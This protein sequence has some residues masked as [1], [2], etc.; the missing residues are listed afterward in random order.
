MSPDLGRF[1]TYGTNHKHAPLCLRESLYLSPEQLSSVL[2]EVKARHNLRE[3]AVL[4]TCNRLEMYGVK[5][6]HE[7]EDTLLHI[8]NDLQVLSQKKQIHNLKSLS[9]HTFCHM[10]KDAI[11]HVFQVAASIDSLI[12]GETQITGQFKSAFTLAHK[13]STLGPHLYHL[14]QNALRVAKKVRSE[15][16]IGQKTVSIGHAAIDLSRKIFTNLSEK[17]LLL[18]GAGDIAQVTGLY[19]QKVGIQEISIINRSLERAQNLVDLLGSGKIGLLSDLEHFL[20]HADIVIT[21]MTSESPIITAPMMKSI[22]SKRRNRPMYIVD[23]AIP[24]NVDSKCGDFE[25]VYLFELDDLNHYINDNLLER[26]TAAKEA[27]K[28]ID[29]HLE[30]FCHRVERQPE[31]LIIARYHRYLNQIL[32]Q[33]FQKSLKRKEL[34]NLRNEEKAAI[35]RMIH[36]I[37]QKLT[38]DFAIAVKNADRINKDHF[39]EVVHEITKTN[40]I[41]ES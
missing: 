35:Q 21:A 24:R 33:E 30:R 29:I 10:G 17:K 20:Q 6:S 27:Q 19:A 2:P 12:V 32:Q 16:V 25:N 13:A 28:I 5:N 7:G 15:T 38:A 8:F 34:M 1:F 37:G 3:I 39:K 14:S 23:I 11:Q 4:S 22:L 18:L 31:S 36:S 40:F 41:S 9:E 26:E